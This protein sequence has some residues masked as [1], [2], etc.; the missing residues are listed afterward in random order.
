[1]CEWGI[2]IVLELPDDIN[3]EKRNRTVSIDACIAEVIQG[4]WK[5]GCQT[6]SCC[7]GHGKEYASLVVS[8]G[9]DEDG[10]HRIADFLRDNDTR[11]WV[12]EQWKLMTV[13]MTL[14]E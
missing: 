2:E 11:P 6:R 9:Y 4:L 13:A 7:C 1:M 5:Q 12:I 8:S 10:V 14:P 3:P